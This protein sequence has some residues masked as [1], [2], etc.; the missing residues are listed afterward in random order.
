MPHDENHNNTRQKY[1]I[2]EG[3]FRIY[4]QLILYSNI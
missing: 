1:A 2:S 3:I 4:A